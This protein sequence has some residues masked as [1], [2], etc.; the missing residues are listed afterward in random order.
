MGQHIVSQQSAVTVT[1]WRGDDMG[2]AILHA[3]A[4][5]RQGLVQGRS[6]IIDSRQD[7]AVQ[8]EH[9]S[10]ASSPNL[11][12]NAPKRSNT[13]PFHSAKLFLSISFSCLAEFSDSFSDGAGIR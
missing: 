11:F 1:M 13:A 6:P 9:V 12:W 7:M 3:E 4:S 10:T 2:D 5:Y 8:V